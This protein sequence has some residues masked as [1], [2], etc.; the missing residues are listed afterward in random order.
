MIVVDAV[1]LME[2]FEG[3]LWLCE[4]PYLAD[5]AIRFFLVSSFVC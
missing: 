1:M 2:L 5:L 4:K 3:K